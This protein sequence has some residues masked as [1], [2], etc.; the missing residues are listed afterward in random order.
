MV[1]TMHGGE[2]P[3]N[4]RHESD[5]IQSLAED[6]NAYLA[7]KKSTESPPFAVRRKGG[8]MTDD[9]QEEWEVVSRG[10]RCGGLYY[11]EVALK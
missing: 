8:A 9:G 11:G 1:G 5:W 6:V 7:A 10:R 4:G 2:N 3:G